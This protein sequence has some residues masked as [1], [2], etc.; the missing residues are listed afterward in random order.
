MVNLTVDN[1]GGK[2]K[3]CILTLNCKV[4]GFLPMYYEKF[5]FFHAITRDDN[6]NPFHPPS[7]LR[8]YNDVSLNQN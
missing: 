7:A 1:D 5:C 2:L 8:R 4:C 3:N 6:T